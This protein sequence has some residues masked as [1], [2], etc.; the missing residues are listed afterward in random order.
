MVTNEPRAHS[1]QKAGSMKWI[2]GIV[3]GLCLVGCGVGVDDP[4]G[5]AASGYEAVRS[6][7]QLAA[8]ATDAEGTA[9]GDDAF[10][11]VETRAPTSQPGVSDP[12]PAYVT[13]AGGEVS[14]P[15]DPIPAVDPVQKP[16]PATPFG[17]GHP[18]M[19]KPGTD[20]RTRM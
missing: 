11:S 10:D 13:P 19:N 8:G 12:A 4:E 2:A 20:P 3:A 7:E 17:D 1:L 18:D 15:Q 9:G 14:A 6:T 5:L 16:L